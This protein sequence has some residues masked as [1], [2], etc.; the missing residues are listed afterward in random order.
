MNV[1]SRP[2]L[3]L[4]LVVLVPLLAIG[5]CPV[6]ASESSPAI[7]SILFCEYVDNSD[8][9]VNP[10]GV[11]PSGTSLVTVWFEF[12]Q[13]P[14]SSSWG[15]RLYREDE[16]V[17]NAYYPL[18]GWGES[19]SGYRDLTREGGFDDGTYYLTFL[20]NGKEAGSGSFSVG[21][22]SP[23]SEPEGSVS[24]GSFGRIIFAEGATD[25]SAPINERDQFDAGITEIYMIIPYYGMTDGEVWSREWLLDGTVIASTDEAW[26]EGAEGITYRYL[27]N[28]DGSSFS[29]GRY[30][31]NLYLGDQIARSAGFT[32]AGGGEQKEERKGKTIEELVDP[33]LMKAY[34]VLA[35]SDNEAL[36]ILSTLI[37]DNGITVGFSRDIPGSG[38]YRFSG[39]ADPGE[40]V[41]SPDYWNEVS[42]EEVAGVVAHELTHALQRDAKGGMVTCTVEN[43]YLAFLFEFYAL[44]ESGRSDLFYEKFGGAFNADG[45]LNKQR[46]WNAVK[47]TYSDCPDE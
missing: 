31:V 32:I 34:D 21:G 37:P 43:E 16:L 30:T 47:K 27:Y 11:F 35:Y 10:T 2:F 22:D 36:R 26:Y 17:Q 24:S 42:W 23:G 1:R 19:G 44:Q 41:I 18:W 33:D 38:Q 14:P 46:L 45:S 15:F 7:T 28:G 3:P 39:A 6:S 12:E 13:V 29:P 8:N 5:L 25:E 20:V 9:P 40:I 4:V